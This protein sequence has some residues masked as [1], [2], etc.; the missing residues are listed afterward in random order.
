MTDFWYD[1]LSRTLIYPGQAPPHVAPWLDGMKQNGKFFVVPH[2]L[3]NSIVLRYY[4]YPVAPI[5]NGSYGFASDLVNSTYG[6]LRFGPGD[7]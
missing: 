4:N 2:S 6:F 7:A 3:Q 5:M 1:A